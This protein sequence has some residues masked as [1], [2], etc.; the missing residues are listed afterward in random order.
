[1]IR[2]ENK[3]GVINDTKI[4]DTETGNI[5]KSVFGVEIMPFDCKTD[6]LIQVNLTLSRSEIDVM[7]EKQKE[8][9][10]DKN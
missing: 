3:T 1:M 7:C 10:H 9:Y 5:I 4:I 6:G 2:I 8:Q